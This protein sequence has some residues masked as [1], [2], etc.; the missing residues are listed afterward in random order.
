MAKQRLRFMMSAALL[1]LGLTSCSA[2]KVAQCNSF[3]EVINQA[4]GFKTEFES[5]INTFTQQA[6]GAKSLADIQ[7]A[8]KQYIGAVDKVVGNI[9]GMVTSLNGL[10]LPDETLGQ[11]R[12]EYAS[13]ITG[14]AS[15][16]KVAADAMKMVSDAKSEADLAKVLEGFQT[17]ANGAFTKLQDLSTQESTLVT[18][19]NTYCGAEGGEAAA[20]AQ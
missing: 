11:Y 10:E 7:G 8:A 9:D 4:Q 13:I 3:A 16:L 6:S 20:P 1:T 2:S 15:E 17:K 5:D 12:T 19:I 18:N 14:S